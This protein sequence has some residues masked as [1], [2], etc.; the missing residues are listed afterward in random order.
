MEQSLPMNPF[1]TSVA[2]INGERLRKA[3]VLEA[4]TEDDIG[5]VVMYDVNCDHVEFGFIKSWNDLYVFVRYGSGS[6]A[7]ATPP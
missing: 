1:A 3:V 4:L 2:L 6:P 5:R 7:R